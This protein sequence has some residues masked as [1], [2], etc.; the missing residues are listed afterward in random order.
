MRPGAQVR[1]LSRVRVYR[2]GASLG[3]KRDLGDLIVVA[4][5]V[6]ELDLVLPRVLCR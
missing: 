4:A 1:R 6:G 2:R 3:R 5:R